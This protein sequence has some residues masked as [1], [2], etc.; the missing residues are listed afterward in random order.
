MTKVLLSAFACN[1]TDGSE[2]SYGWNWAVGLAER[3]FEVRCITR[4]TSKVGIG[5]KSLPDNLKFSYLHL[6]RGL[7]KLYSTSEIGQYLYYILWQWQA[8]K[9][10]AD[11]HKVDKFDIVHHITFGSL[12]MGSFMYKLD[13]PLVF[14]PVGG[15]QM[16]PVAFKKYFGDAWSIENYRNRMSRL[17]LKFN[18]ACRNALRK[19][20]VVLAANED[21]LRL[22][23]SNGA[24]NAFLTFDVG[25]P[26]WFFPE[27]S[28]VK[29]PHEG[30]LKLLWVGRLMPRK[31][32][33]LLLDVM[34]EL[35]DYP[36]ITLT[37]VGDGC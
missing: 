35:K 20:A 14:G 15:G 25:L 24:R 26:G 16:A 23:E 30:R 19:A 34:K 29:V 36:G 5:T 8:Y 31:G 3:G 10:A 1:P 22:A 12:Q 21:T 27:T 37:V 2:P 17:L 7:E 6:P 33:L 11:M 32:P 9:L 28:L 13:I 4:S 18:P